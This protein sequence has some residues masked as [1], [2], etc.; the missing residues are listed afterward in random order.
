MW[1]QYPDWICIS[2]WL[3]SCIERCN[4]LSAT[5]YMLVDVIHWIE[6]MVA[7]CH[8]WV[9]FL[10]SSRCC[11]TLKSN[12]GILTILRF[13]ISRE[14][15]TSKCEFWYFGGRWK[16]DKVALQAVGI[17]NMCMGFSTLMNVIAFPGQI[18]V[19]VLAGVESAVVRIQ[20]FGAIWDGMLMSDVFLICNEHLEEMLA[21]F[22]AYKAEIPCCCNTWSMRLFLNSVPLPDKM[23]LGHMST[24][25]YS[26]INL[27]TIVST[28][29]SG[30]GYV[31]GQPVRWSIIVSMCLFSWCRCFTFCDEIYCYFIKRYV[32]DFHHFKRVILNLGLLPVT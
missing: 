7:K 31:S 30:M 21:M 2:C 17:L 14:M 5:D 10:W 24:G 28:V 8:R 6:G 1:K 13:A 18:R 32:R 12:D 11:H 19:I 4:M 25:R 27:E 3:I 16:F 23:Y 15:F 9:S 20:T 22:L 26:F 29:L